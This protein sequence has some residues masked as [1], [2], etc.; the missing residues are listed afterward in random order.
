MRIGNKLLHASC[1]SSFLK[2]KFAETH[3]ER[4]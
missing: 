4:K 1:Y 2:R 3:T